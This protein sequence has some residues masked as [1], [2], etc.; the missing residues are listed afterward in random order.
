MA[1]YDGVQNIKVDVEDSP[2]GRAANDQIAARAAADLDWHLAALHRTMAKVEHPDRTDVT[3]GQ[4]EALIVAVDAM[5]RER[6]ASL[7]A[8][9]MVRLVWI[10]ADHG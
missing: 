5:P 4:A 2:A 8:V 10:E 6:L 1:E 9:A 3:A 7:L